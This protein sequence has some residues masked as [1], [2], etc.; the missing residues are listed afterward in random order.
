MIEKGRNTGFTIVELLIVIVVIGI[1]AAI[2][3]VAYSG[4]QQRARDSQRDSD[5]ATVAK[6]LELYYVDNGQFP[7][8]APNGSTATGMGN[9]WAVTT[10]GSWSALASALVPK[11][12]SKLPEEPIV[13]TNA[14]PRF[15]VAMGYAYYANTST[16][17]GK[18]TFQMYILVY[19]RESG[20][21]K[22]V[23]S[24]DC[25]TNVLTYSAASN[26]RVTK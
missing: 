18:A 17:C 23:Y 13:Q 1:L 9:Y 26:Y 25:T 16:Y 20:S 11:Y 19:K 22:N 21:Q 7:V 4:I 8:I 14:D 24:G 6:A 2:T 5:I 15:G 3:I 12:I 10:D